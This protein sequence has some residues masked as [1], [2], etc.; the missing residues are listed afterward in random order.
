MKGTV[1]AQKALQ[2]SET[3]TRELLGRNGREK[4]F[5]DEGS[6]IC[7]PGF[8][9][10]RKQKKIELE[11]RPALGTGC[12]ELLHRLLERVIAEGKCFSSD[13]HLEF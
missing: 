7:P 3:E 9:T 6:V 10:K 2:G 13:P 8:C 1:L 5:P 4:Y 12:R 11:A